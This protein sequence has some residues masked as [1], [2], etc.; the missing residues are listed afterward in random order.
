[1]T[2]SYTGTDSLENVLG[3]YSNF[4]Q[5]KL[6]TRNDTI[7]VKLRYYASGNVASTYK[8]NS[9]TIIASNYNNENTLKYFCHS[10]RQFV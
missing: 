2:I 1:M 10:C 9:N 4:T 3:Y 5:H 6:E 7:V 8:T